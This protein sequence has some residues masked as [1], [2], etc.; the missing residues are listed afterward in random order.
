[1]SIKSDNSY[2]KKE[3]GRCITRFLDQY[4]PWYEAVKNDGCLSLITGN[5]DTPR[6]SRGLSPRELG[7]AYALFFTMPGVPFLYYGDEIAMR[8]LSL[9]TKEGG[10]T[11]TG[12]RTPMQWKSGKNLGF[13]A[14][15]P[16]QLYLPVDGAPDA[17]TVESQ[18]KDSSSLLN[19]V[20]ALLRLRHAETDLQAKP[21]LEILHAGNGEAGDRSFIYRRGSHICAVNP[22]GQEVNVPAAASC[23]AAPRFAIGNCEYGGGYF[24]LGAQ[25][26]GV[27]KS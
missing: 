24:R 14:A 15:P 21:N 17:P 23:P 27:W 9:P 12:S 2:F 8:Y 25:S 16:E 18:E 20:K 22:G 11:R 7:L 4:L 13:S 19:T 1:L 10:Y 6:I 5:H 26:F 3:S